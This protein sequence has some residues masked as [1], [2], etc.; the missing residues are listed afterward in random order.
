MATARENREK[1]AEVPREVNFLAIAREFRGIRNRNPVLRKE[2]I[3]RSLT[4]VNTVNQT[5]PTKTKFFSKA[6]EHIPH[7]STQNTELKSHR[8]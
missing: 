1:P 7:T 6:T 2:R 5:T 4:L 3:A 8:M